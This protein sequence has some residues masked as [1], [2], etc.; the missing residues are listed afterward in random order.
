MISLNLANLIKPIVAQIPEGDLKLPKPGT[1]SAQ[2]QA[3]LSLVFK[4]A[5]AV[6]VIVIIVAGIS[7]IVSAGDP[8]RTAKAKDA[9][10]YAIIGLF[11]AILA[12]AIV[13]LTISKAV[14]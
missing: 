1:S 2:I 11:V 8:Q 7:Y 3:V 14:G 12:S 13:Q 5:G 4:I 10:L 6:A 9:I